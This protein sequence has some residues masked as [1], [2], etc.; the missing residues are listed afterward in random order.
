MVGSRHNTCGAI[1]AAFSL[2][3]KEGGGGGGKRES[4]RD[5]GF[6]TSTVVVKLLCNLFPLKEG[7]GMGGG[8]G[9]G[10]KTGVHDITV[11]MRLLCTLFPIS[12][13]GC[14]HLVLHYRFIK[15]QQTVSAKTARQAQ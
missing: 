11:V 1:F 13:A 4:E 10:G 14:M 9:G 5:W 12:H 6:K 7:G 3:G 8:G 2:G 15:P